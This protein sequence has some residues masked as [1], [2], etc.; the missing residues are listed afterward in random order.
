MIPRFRPALGWQELSALFSTEENAVEQFEAAFAE[1]FGG[2]E[3]IA[4]PYG[5]S[6]LWATFNALG[7]NDCDVLVTPYTCSVVAHA[8]TLSNNRAKFVDIQ[9]SD[10]NMNLDLLAEAIDKNTRAI[11]ATHIFG[12]PA[13]LTKLETIVEE[14]EQRFGHKILVIQDCAHSFDTEWEGRRVCEAGDAALYGLNISKVMTSIFGGMMTLQDPA[15]ANK[16]RMWRDAN[17]AQASTFRSWQRRMYL[18]AACA[19]FS[20]PLYSFVWW[21]QNR[22]ATLDS[23]TRE[24]HLDDKI[25]F[26]PDHLTQMINVEAGVGL[27]QLRKYDDIVERRRENARWYDDNLPRSDDF[28]LPPIVDGATY[29]HY[30]VRSTRRDEIVAAISKMG[31]ELGRVIDYCVPDLES[32][33]STVRCPNASIASNT[34]LNLPLTVDD[35]ERNRVKQALE[36]IL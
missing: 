10:Y 32:Y 22:T 26:P 35:T 15:L 19:A 2:H 25:H 5:R 14:A 18:L 8:I 31:I 34:V 33:R 7:I 30:A 17:F 36:T 1:R 20:K 9:L 4:F 16:T 23:L 21:L 12:Y 24:Y 6:A 3:A 28:V 13:D 29:S 11:I 27:V